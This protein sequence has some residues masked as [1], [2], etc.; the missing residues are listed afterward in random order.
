MKP[1][2]YANIQAK[3][4]RIKAGYGIEAEADLGSGFTLSGGMGKSFDKGKV[5]YPGGSES[6]DADIPD[7]WRVGLKYSKK[8]NVGGLVKQGK[9]KIA[10]KGWR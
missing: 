10:K 2:L 5:D 7:N 8:F 6:W 1:G 3:R 9:P 4:K